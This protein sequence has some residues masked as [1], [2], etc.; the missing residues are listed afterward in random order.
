M[1]KDFYFRIWTYSSGD[2]ATIDVWYQG[3]EETRPNRR[4]VSE[5]AKE[6][7][8]NEDII[9]LFDLDES[10]CWQ[11]FGH[12]RITGSFDY[13]GEYDETTDILSFE[14]AE[15]P[16][17]FNILPFKTLKVKSD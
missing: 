8:E 14:K 10:K 6:A 1:S 2:S 4:F 15:V 5:W 7:L 13:Y 3:L 9:S 12:A 11:I 16:E 17:D